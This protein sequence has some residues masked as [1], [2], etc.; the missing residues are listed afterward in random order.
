MSDIARVGAD[1]SRR[2]LMVFISGA[3]I[4][5]A[6]GLIIGALLTFWIGEGTMRAFHEAIRHLKGADTQPQFDVLLQ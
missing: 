6:T 2:Q 5:S 4:G 1:I 3:A